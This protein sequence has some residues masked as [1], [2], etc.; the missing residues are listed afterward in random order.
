MY[1]TCGPRCN[2]APVKFLR[3][4]HD[5][6]D[7]TCDKSE[8]RARHHLRFHRDGFLVCFEEGAEILK[9]KLT[10]RSSVQLPQEFLRQLCHSE[11]PSCQRILAS[12]KT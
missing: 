12:V 5:L 8:A 10:G 4:S 6:Q 1:S 2:D 3:I 7:I 11:A 9:A